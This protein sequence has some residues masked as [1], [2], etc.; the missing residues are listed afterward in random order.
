MAPSE[1]QVIVSEFLASLKE[2]QESLEYQTYDL[3]E[4]RELAIASCKENDTGTP[5]SFHQRKLHTILEG[6]SGLVVCRLVMSPW[7][8]APG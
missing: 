8:E 2:K 3:T 7:R 4:R 5:T 1:D 6:I